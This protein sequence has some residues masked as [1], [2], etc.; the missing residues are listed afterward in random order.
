MSINKLFLIFPH[1]LFEDISEIPNGSEIVLIEY[2]DNSCK[3]KLR[4]HM[5]SMLYYQDYLKSKGFKV[6]WV[7]KAKRSEFVSK[8]VKKHDKYEITMYDPTE[9]DIKD[10]LKHTKPNYIETPYFLTTHDELKKYCKGKN[11]DTARQEA[12]YRWQRKRLNALMKDGKPF[13]GK[14]NYDKMNQKSVGDNLPNVPKTSP[15][16]H[17]AAKKYYKLAD[18]RI[19]YTSNNYGELGFEYPCTHLSARSWLTSFLKKK[20]HLFGR[21]QDVVIDPDSMK[22]DRAEF[23]F[24]S[25]LSPMLN[26]GLL[27]PK[28]VLDKTLKYYDKHRKDVPLN[29][30]EGFV[31]QLI[32][33][34]EFV[35]FKYEYSKINPKMNF[36]KNKRKISK[37]F[38]DGSTGLKP[39][40]DMIKSALRTSYSHHIIRLMWL[41]SFF[42]LNQIHPNDVLNWFMELYVDAY[43]WVMV[44]NVTG[45]SQYADDGMIAT[46]PYFS[47]SAY[48]KKMS[49]YVSDSKKDEKGWDEK[50]DLLYYK[51]LNDKSE[52]LVEMYIVSNWVRAWKNKPNDEKKKMLKE[53]NKTIV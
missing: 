18:K 37:S 49:N 48:L 46:R 31:R 25:V 39:I 17:V 15:G 34:R 7:R 36:F 13:G 53:A 26:V 24:H 45:M 6:K 41:G 27:T 29:S 51:F 2:F 47:S 22:D 19:S 11:P 52:K 20:L 28:D 21:Y 38:Y 35:R 32:G 42:L 8:L 9:K 5:A 44:P 4:L 14:F 30:V 33:W 3:N 1:Q 12:F 23:M 10:L 50:W 40:D 16:S 43:M